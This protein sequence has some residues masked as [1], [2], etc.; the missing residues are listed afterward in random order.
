MEKFNPTHNDSRN[1]K[2]IKLIIGIGNPGERY[3]LTYHNAGLLFISFIRE[4]R[5]GRL[6][7][8]THKSGKFSYTRLDGT[9]IAHP[10]TFMNSSGNAVLKAMKFFGIKPEEIL[11]V[12]DDSDILLSKYKI[13]FGRGAA[14]HHGISSIIELTGTKSFWRLRIGIRKAALW[15]TKKAGSFVLKKINPSDRKKITELFGEIAVK[16]GLSAELTA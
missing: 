9:I 3:K 15:K 12:H 11:I 2:G 6:H 7:F 10:L 8:K 16:L 4:N 1:I 5:R 13:C 14:G